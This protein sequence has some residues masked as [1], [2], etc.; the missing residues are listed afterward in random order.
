MFPSTCTCVAAAPNHYLVIACHCCQDLT[1]VVALSKSEAVFISARVQAQEQQL[2]A[3]TAVAPE[4]PLYNSS[5]ISDAG[6][7]DTAE[8]E[9]AGTSEGEDD[10]L[11][12]QIEDH[13]SGYSD[14]IGSEHGSTTTTGSFAEPPAPKLRELSPLI[15]VRVPG[16][17]RADCVQLHTICLSGTRHVLQNNV[18]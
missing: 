11:P 15:V 17:N 6:T 9:L 2:A 7:A 1:D 12:V 4:Q 18:S 14:D 8:A 13:V 5:A 16:K 10:G 3:H